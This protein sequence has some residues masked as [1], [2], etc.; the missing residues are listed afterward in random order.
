MMEIVV[1]L[2]LLGYI[3]WD[4]AGGREAFEYKRSRFFRWL[5]KKR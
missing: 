2:I 4:K 3:W 5:F 1:F